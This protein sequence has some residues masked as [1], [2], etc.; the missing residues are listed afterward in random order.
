MKKK[1]LLLIFI[2]IIGFS[3]IPVQAK[4]FK[5]FYADENVTIDKNVDSSLFAAGESIDVN[6]TVDGNS[7]LAANEIKLAGN[8]DS[9]F[10]AGKDISLNEVYT[11]DAY[12]AGQNIKIESSNIRD[13]FVMSDTV[14]ITSDIT[15]NAYIGCSSVTINSYIAGDVYIAAETIK[16]GENAVIDGTLK[17][18]SDAKITI[19]ENAQV[20]KEVTYTSTTNTSKTTN[21][22]TVIMNRVSSFLGLLVAGLV[23]LFGYNKL[24]KEIEKEKFDSNTIVKTSVTGLVTLIVLPIA[25]IVVMCTGIGLSISLISLVVYF[26]LLYLSSIVTA[27]YFGNK[28]LKK[29]ID[30]QY[31]LLTASLACLY[32]IKLIPYIGGIV[33][34]I[35]LCFGLGFLFNIVKPHPTKK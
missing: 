8:H 3:I 19:D 28:Y 13:L 17:Y 2:L 7:F 35:S 33:G 4:S 9:V 16:L 18:P 25:A 11:K 26:I 24:F 14:K 1:G 20:A 30:N 34:F 10:V 32:V 23:L 6:A 31:L 27:Y 12:V 5:G 29:K 15:G 21:Y 22:A